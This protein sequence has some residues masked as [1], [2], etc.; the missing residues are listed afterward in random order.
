M[1][2]GPAARR[3]S[4]LELAAGWGWPVGLAH[5]S[6]HPEEAHPPERGTL[7]SLVS[8]Y[9]GTRAAH[10]YSRGHFHAGVYAIVSSTGWPFHL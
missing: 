5:W 7:C 2:V 10:G 8:L 9:T 4:W 1:V 3:S 6:G